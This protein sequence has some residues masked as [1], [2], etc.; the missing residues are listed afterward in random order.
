MDRG[1]LEAGRPRKGNDRYASEY[2]LMDRQRRLDKIVNEGL[3]NIDKLV[4]DKP[5]LS[6]RTSRRKPAKLYKMSGGLL[7]DSDLSK[8][9]ATSA[10]ASQTVTAPSSSPPI[11]SPTVGQNAVTDLANSPPSSTKFS[12]D[13]HTP[14][15]EEDVTPDSIDPRLLVMSRS[16]QPCGTVKLSGLA[17]AAT[18]G[19]GASEKSGSNKK[20]QKDDR[21]PKQLSPTSDLSGE[22]RSSNKRSVHS[23]PESDCS[24]V[25]SDRNQVQERQPRRETPI[26]APQPW[27]RL[28]LKTPFESSTPLNPTE[29]NQDFVL[30]T[31]STP[32]SNRKMRRRPQALTNGHI[33]SVDKTA[34]AS[35]PLVRSLHDGS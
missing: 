27:L 25:Q 23:P 19:H 32:P 22:Q 30:P 9:Y 2:S 17:S 29:E 7:T 26:P 12:G 28:G 31:P 35:S 13:L 34:P 14:S 24:K 10:M 6:S 21:M 11:P 15:V 8:V 20:S 16:P 5:A 4:Y 3:A 18:S 1:M 33:S